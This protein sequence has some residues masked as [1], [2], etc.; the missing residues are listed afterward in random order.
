MKKSKMWILGGVIIVL[1]LVIA[2]VFE[3]TKT[4]ETIGDMQMSNRITQNV[5][6]NV[7][8]N[9]L[10]NDVP[11]NQITNT[12]V[13]NQ[14]TQNTTH[15]GESSEI[16]QEEPKTAEEKVI[17]ITKKDWGS[18]DTSVKYSVEGMDSEGR[19]VV[20]VRD[21]QTTEARAFYYVSASSGEFI[22]QEMN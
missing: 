22:K 17:A 15:S 9:E 14:V 19:Y 3:M 8:T 4:K 6:A 11:T 20:V 5:E 16:L 18:S 10:A 12:P 1:I 21:K 13:E 7:Q 2:L